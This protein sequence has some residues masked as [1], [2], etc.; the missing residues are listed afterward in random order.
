[1]YKIFHAGNKSYMNPETYLDSVQMGIN[2][3]QFTVNNNNTY[4]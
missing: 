1:M 4:C 3:T 2:K